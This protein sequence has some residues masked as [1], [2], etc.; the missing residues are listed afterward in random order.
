MLIQTEP[1]WGYK[2][3]KQ[4]EAKFGVKLRHGALYPLLNA[5]DQNGFLTSQK[6]RQGRRIRK[7]YTITKKGKQYIDAY[8]DVLKEQIERKDIK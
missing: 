1:T 7:V 4:V 2:I 8:N 5:L 3:K 6:Q